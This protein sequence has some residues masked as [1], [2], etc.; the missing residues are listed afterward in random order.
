MNE[1]ESWI[2]NE[3]AR[4]GNPL[5]SE[6]NASAADPRDG[7]STRQRDARADSTSTIDSSARA[8]V[9][10]ACSSTKT[11]LTVRAPPWVTHP[12]NRTGTD[13]ARASGSSRTLV[14]WQGREREALPADVA[15]RRRAALSG[16]PADA[17]A[18]HR[19]RRQ[20]IA[21]DLLHLTVLHPNPGDEEEI[22]AFVGRWLKEQALAL[23]APRVAAFR[24]PGHHVVADGQ[25]VQR[26]HAMG[27]VQPQG[28]DQAQL[29]AGAVA[30]AH[31]RL[32]GRARGR[33]PDR[34]E[35]FAALLGAGRGAAARPRRGPSR[36]RRADAAAW[37]A[38]TRRAARVRSRAGERLSRAR[39]SVTAR[40]DDR[41]PPAR[42]AGAR[43]RRAELGAV[44]R[45]APRAALSLENES[46]RIS[47]RPRS[48][49]WA[50]D[51]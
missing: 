42:A 10:S 11:G 47:P 23:L 41:C 18:V 25:A 33:A 22:G 30:A 45:V 19:A 7:A 12:R 43:K 37:L 35:P 17:R 29:A 39:G 27:H 5:A 40:R 50:D 9:R 6:R 26:A 36:A 51:G 21:A 14:E 16:T 8:A 48:R 31:R 13:R 49:D 15:R 1:V 20:T 46:R 32:R 44:A 28:R 34:A 3:V 24:E 4:L 2:E 38:R